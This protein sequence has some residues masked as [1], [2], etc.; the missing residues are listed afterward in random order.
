MEGLNNTYNDEMANSH[1]HSSNHESWLTTPSIN[2]HDCGNGSY[3]HHNADNSRSKKG[4]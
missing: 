2:V 3:E 4:D 1:A